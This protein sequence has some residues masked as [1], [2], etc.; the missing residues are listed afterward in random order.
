MIQ[1]L[2]H[3]LRRLARHR[4]FTAS[5]ILALAFAI[6]ANAALF[7]VIN[8]LLLTPLPYDRVAELVAIDQPR[9]ELPL[10]ELSRMRSFS[11]VAGLLGWSFPVG[12]R[13]E[14]RN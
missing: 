10:Q 11:G 2:R 9:R 12:A 5:V 4:G 7:A 6:G 13:G 3:S 14:S 1:D 8:S